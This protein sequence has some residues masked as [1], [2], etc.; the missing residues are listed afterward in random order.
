[1]TDALA[2]ENRMR[3]HFLL[4]FSFSNNIVKT[5]NPAYLFLVIFVTIIYYLLI[6]L[7]FTHNPNRR[8]V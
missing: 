5:F 3:N 8:F 7:L 4:L 1:M 2:Y 6:P